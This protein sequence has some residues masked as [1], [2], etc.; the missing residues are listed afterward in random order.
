MGR[1]SGKSQLCEHDER[2]DLSTK[3]FRE[4]EI[5]AIAEFETYSEGADVVGASGG[6]E[7]AAENRQPGAQS[8][9]WVAPDQEFERKSPGEN[10]IYVD[11]NKIKQYG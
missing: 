10:V 6:K 9:R 11:K 4:G 8:R 5:F 3:K 2:K 7:A 1:I